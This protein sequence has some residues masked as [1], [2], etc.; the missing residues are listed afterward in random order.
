[1]DGGGWW[2]WTENA[3]GRHNHHGGGY[4]LQTAVFTLKLKAVASV[5]FGK[6]FLIVCWRFQWIRLDAI[7]ATTPHYPICSTS[8]QSKTQCKHTTLH[9]ASLSWSPGSVCDDDLPSVAF[10]P[11]QPFTVPLSP[12]KTRRRLPAPAP[13]QP[14]FDLNAT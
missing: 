5:L 9:H 13:V 4:V 11:T 12:T 1:L 8:I 14:D 2:G 3:L 7:A 10:A 6:S